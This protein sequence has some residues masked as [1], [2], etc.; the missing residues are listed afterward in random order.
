M[1]R[2]LKRILP[3]F[4]TLVIICSIIWY[5]FVYDRGIMQD[6]LLGSARFFEQQGNHNIATWLY[7]QAYQQSGNDDTVIIEENVDGFEVGCAVLGIDKLTVG[8]VDEIELKNGFFDFIE[9]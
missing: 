5:L 3:I 7:N 8:R 6:M 9:M 2:T 1:K 4:L